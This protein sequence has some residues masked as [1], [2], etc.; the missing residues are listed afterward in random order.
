MNSTTTSDTSF[1]TTYIVDRIPDEVYVAI[2]DVG[3]WWTGKVDGRADH[4]GDEFTYQFGDLHNSRQRVT[5]LV[6]GH[7]IVWE[8]VDAQLSGRSTPDEWRGT[9]IVF[10]LTPTKAG[11]SVQFTHDG[12]VPD[13]ECYDDCAYAW[14]FF[15][16]RSLMSLITTGEGPTTT[17]WT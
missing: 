14:T 16:N 8:V 11:T 13:F 7:R 5:E 12:L 17:P 9:H 1:T 4:V 3:R 10:V 6:P 2:N 15:L